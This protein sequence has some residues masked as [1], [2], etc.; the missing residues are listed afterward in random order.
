M[1]KK[2]LILIL[3]IGISSNSQTKLDT[4]DLKYERI[5]FAFDPNKKDSTKFIK[6]RFFKNEILKSTTYDFD[7]NEVLEKIKANIRTVEIPFYRFDYKTFYSKTTLDM[8]TQYIKKIFFDVFGYPDSLKTSEKYWKHFRN[9]RISRKGK[10]RRFENDN[11]TYTYNYN[12]F[13]KLKSVIGTSPTNE[14]MNYHFRKDRLISKTF[15]DKKRICTYDKE[16]NLL[17]DR[18]DFE[19][20]IVKRNFNSSNNVTEMLQYNIENNS[21]EFTWKT[22][23][24]YDNK[25]R[26]IKEKFYDKNDKL[27]LTFKYYYDR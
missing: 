9:K 3:L 22:L 2:L 16:G 18:N 27:N 23:Y 11:F 12:L 20:V 8:D 6:E 13:G 1:K 7:G 10:I 19:S 25:D 5:C 24:Y 21:S 17:I 14:K 26:L 15:K 4:T